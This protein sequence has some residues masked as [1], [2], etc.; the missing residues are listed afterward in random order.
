MKSPRTLLSSAIVLLLLGAGCNG[1]A[2]DDTAPG[3]EGDDTGTDTPQDD[4]PLIAPTAAQAVAV[5]DVVTYT[6]TGLKEAQAYR[7]T[8]VS[9]ANITV[10]DGSGVFIDL[11]ANGAADAG[12]SN[13]VA[14]IVRVNSDTY[15]GSKTV[16]AT[17]DDPA[18]PA[19]IFAVDGEIQVD[20]AAVGAGRAWLVAYENGGTSTFLEIDSAGVP[21]EPHVVSGAFEVASD[22]LPDVTPA[23]DRTIAVAETTLVSITDLDDSQAYRVTLVVADNIDRSG[24]APVFTD[25]DLNGAADAGASEAVALITA[26]QGEAITGAKTWPA[27]TDDP[28]APTGIFPSNGQILIEISG[29]GAGTILPVAYD[30]GG[31][32]TFLE[33]DGSGVPSERHGIGGALTVTP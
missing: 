14:T 27:G 19:G 6:L 16:P 9:D 24:A 4:N 11:D 13:W 31:A 5:G 21:T 23:H 26:V 12:D 3:G 7:V 22:G 8:L 10:T 33:L 29:V 17:D 28:A 32:S 25:D 15:P 20:V 18:F 1:K 2:A 30:N